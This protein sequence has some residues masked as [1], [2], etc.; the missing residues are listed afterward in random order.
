MKDDP[1]SRTILF[2]EPARRDLD[3]LRRHGFSV[4]DWQ[5]LKANLQ[6]VARLPDV[7]DCEYVCELRMC[8]RGDP[9]W[10]RLKQAHLKSAG[11]SGVRVAFEADEDTL[12][13]WCVLRRDHSTY[14]IVEARLRKAARGIR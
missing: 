14:E 1:Y 9:T 12:T 6:T 2:T 8:K 5:R 7:T 10:Y 4:S 11:S 3:W 13:V